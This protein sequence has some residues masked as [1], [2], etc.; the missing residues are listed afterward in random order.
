MSHGTLQAERPQTPMD[1][2]PVPCSACLLGALSVTAAAV[3][4]PRSR[5]LLA[6]WLSALPLR[7][8]ARLAGRWTGRGRARRHGS[9]AAAPDA[10]RVKSP[11]QQE[12]EPGQ[13][14][15]RLGAGRGRM[16][17]PRRGLDPGSVWAQR[18]RQLEQRLRVRGR[19]AGRGRALQV[20]TCCGAAR[21][22]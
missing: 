8:G 5:S 19:G 18:L 6:D 21:R 13:F 7:D 12:P 3:A 22:P 11:P 9:R 17:W 14:S 10:S 1:S 15:L 4:P 16:M 2:T 20:S